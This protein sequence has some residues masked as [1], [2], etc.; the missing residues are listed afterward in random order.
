MGCPRLRCGLSRLS[1]AVFWLSLLGVVSSVILLG[2]ALRLKMR[3]GDHVDLVVPGGEGYLWP[4]TAGLA[5]VLVAPVHVLGLMVVRSGVNKDFE[6]GRK[7]SSGRCRE[8][9]KSSLGRLL[10]LHTLL[11]CLSGLLVLGACAGSAYFWSLSRR[12]VRPGLQRAIR[13]YPAEPIIKTRVDRLQIELGC[14]GTESYV[15]W[16]F[17]DWKRPDDGEYEELDYFAEEP[18]DMLS[19]DVPYSC[20]S[21]EAQ[22]ACVHQSINGEPE[23]DDQLTIFSEGCGNKLLDRADRVGRRLLVCLLVIS[24][25]Q[26]AVHLHSLKNMTRTIDHQPKSD[27]KPIQAVAF[28]LQLTLS[29]LSRLLRAAKPSDSANRRGE[30]SDAWIFGRGAKT[31]S[32]RPREKLEPLKVRRSRRLGQDSVL[33]SQR[34]ASTTS[35]SSSQAAETSS[36]SSNESLYAA[37]SS[38]E[39]KMGATSPRMQTRPTSDADDDEEEAPLERNFNASD[40]Y[41]RFRG[42]LQDT[43]ERR[44]RRQ[45]QDW[46]F[47]DDRRDS[48][49]LPGRRATTLK[50]SSSSCS[51]SQFVL[52]SLVRLRDERTCPVHQRIQPSCCPVHGDANR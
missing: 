15:D 39:E 19:A 29:I 38:P 18:K 1:S 3:V 22:Q 16:F 28:Y 21:S 8:N 4:G 23:A 43:L 36:S 27:V 50:S 51:S 48:F 45:C 17:V 12:R 26:V 34:N 11:S 33:T 24:A 5:V 52:Q 47:V 40:F 44:R 46:Q 30:S 31:T 41:G 6:A 32:R 13:R 25:Y 42:T 7:S 20:C 10:F 49:P 2:W 9:S 14:C 37:S 35:E